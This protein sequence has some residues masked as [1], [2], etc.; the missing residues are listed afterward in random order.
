MDES[1]LITMYMEE[2]LHSF[3]I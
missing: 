3:I 2:I 1:P